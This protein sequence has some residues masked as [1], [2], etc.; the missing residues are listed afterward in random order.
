M[1]VSLFFFQSVSV[2]S[3]R[4][5]YEVNYLLS[6]YLKHFLY[7]IWQSYKCRR[8]KTAGGDKQQRASSNEILFYCNSLNLRHGSTHLVEFLLDGN[9]RYAA[10]SETL[11]RSDA[12]REAAYRESPSRRELNGGKPRR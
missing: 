10:S 11:Y 4:I 1:T 6:N 5:W 7:R 12:G 3:I 2:L 9:D 8:K